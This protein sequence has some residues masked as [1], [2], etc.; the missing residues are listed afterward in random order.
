M[1][2][3]FSSVQ[4]SRH[5]DAVMAMTIEFISGMALSSVLT[6]SPEHREKM[7][8][9]WVRAAERLLQAPGNDQAL[10]PPVNA[11]RES[12]ARFDDQHHH[13]V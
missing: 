6:E 2:G 9:H 8:G 12:R 5:F 10:N 11:A 13:S 1:T 3:L 7:I 4:H